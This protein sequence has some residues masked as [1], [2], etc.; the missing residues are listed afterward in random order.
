MYIYWFGL[1]ELSFAY[2]KDLCMQTKH[3][4]LLLWFLLS[5]WTL[6]IDTNYEN[7][8]RNKIFK[9]EGILFCHAVV[10]IDIMGVHLQLS[11]FSLFFFLT[12]L[13]II[14]IH[15]HILSTSIFSLFKSTF[16]SNQNNYSI[17][18]LWSKLFFFLLVS[19]FI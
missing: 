13:H 11:F 16:T 5:L 17:D 7:H 6:L 18:Y 14:L 19:S 10:L 3:Y 15:V 8:F 1:N 2:P 12:L 9:I 4:F